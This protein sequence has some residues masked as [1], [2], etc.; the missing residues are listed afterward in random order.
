MN[1]PRIAVWALPAVL[2]V[3]G[4]SDTSSPCDD[5]T[6]EFSIRNSVGDEVTSFT[7]SEPVGVRMVVTN[8]GDKAASISI[9]DGSCNVAYVDVVDANRA[10]LWAGACPPGSL[11]ICAEGDV[12][13]EPGEST[14][15]EDFWDQHLQPSGDLAPA[16]TYTGHA[17]DSSECRLSGEKDF[18]LVR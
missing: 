8:A 13:L 6:S 18:T 12:R 5:L 2:L 9:K 14:M 11:C 16:G 1:A 4:C 10:Q 15:I 17:I 3:G 7:E